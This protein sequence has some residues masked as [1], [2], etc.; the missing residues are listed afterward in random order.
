MTKLRYFS[1]TALLL[2]VASYSMG[3]FTKQQADNLVL[4]QILVNELAKVN[5]YSLP[6][7]KST[8]EGLKLF[9]NSPIAVPY[10][11]SWVYFIDDLPFANWNHPCRYLFVNSAN[12]SYSI[13]TSRKYPANWQSSFAAL[14][15]VTQPVVTPLPPNANAVINGLPPDPHK[16]AV[17]INGTDWER[18]WNDCSAMYSTLIQVYGFTKENIFVHYDEGTSFKGSDFDGDVNNPD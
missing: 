9:D 4:N 10:N 15:T 7:T 13:T 8:Q 17:I 3:Q 6:V 1:V 14:S 12:G 16:F 18:Y 2:L 5:V 11:S